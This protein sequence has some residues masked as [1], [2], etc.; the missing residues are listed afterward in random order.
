MDKKTMPTLSD[1]T[2]F[3][4]NL[5]MDRSKSNPGTYSI[6]HQTPCSQLFHTDINRHFR[7]IE[8]Q[9]GLKRFDLICHLSH[10]E[11]YGL[12]GVHEADFH[13]TFPENSVLS[14]DFTLER[15]CQLLHEL[16]KIAWAQNQN[17]LTLDD[18]NEISAGLGDEVLSLIES[19][20]RSHSTYYDF[21]KAA[22]RIE[23]LL[24]CH[25]LTPEDVLVNKGPA[26]TLPLA[27]E[28]KRTAA[29]FQF[30]DQFDA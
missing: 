26:D 18:L 6:T 15:L 27:V 29:G 24:A 25:E 16:I 4:S 1:V 9:F 21:Q 3:T 8:E 2:H 17:M 20:Y 13:A 19:Y 23:E 12:L 10:N 7:E 11:Y 28:F 14:A 30:A 22:K 5:F